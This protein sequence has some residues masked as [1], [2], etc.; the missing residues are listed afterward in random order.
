[1]IYHVSKDGYDNNSGGELA[2]LKTINRAAALAQ[3]GDTVV[4][5]EGE[6]REWVTPARGGLNENTRIT[7][8]AAD[9]ERVVIKGSEIVTDWTHV[10]GT[11]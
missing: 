7:Y 2:P 10:K 5:H 4:V 6:Y 9:G 1:M 11:V 8:T 3:A